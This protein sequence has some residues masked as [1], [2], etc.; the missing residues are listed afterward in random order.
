MRKLFVIALIL[1]TLGLWLATNQQ[2]DGPLELPH[3]KYEQGT[4]NQ[5]FDNMVWSHSS[6]PKLLV[7]YCLFQFRKTT[8]F[9]H[10]VLSSS[11]AAQAKLFGRALW[12]IW[13]GHTQLAK[14]TLDVLQQD[15]HWSLWGK[16]GLLELALHTGNQ[17]QLTSLLLQFNN[18]FLS[19]GNIALIQSYK[20]YEL[21]NT[22]NDLEWIRLEELLNKY[23]IKEIATDSKLLFLKSNVYFVRGQEEF[24]EELLKQ[25]HPQ[26]KNTAEYFYCLV[27]LA[28]LKSGPDN[29]KNII[30]KLAKD[31]PEDTE[32]VLEKVLSDLQ[33]SDPTVQKFALKEIYDIAKL[34]NK[35]SK[36]LLEIMESLLTYHKFEEAGQVFKYLDLNKVVLDDFVLFHTISAWNDI[37]KVEYDSALSKLEKALEMAPKDLAANWLKVLLIKKLERPD[38][39]LRPLKILFTANPYNQSYRNQI[40]YFR[41]NYDMPELESLYQRMIEHH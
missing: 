23:T 22:W 15:G 19:S 10:C 13:L 26:V 34:F 12:E 21:W 30:K 16:V 40:T 39:A 1:G 31:W 3:D 24:L 41:N 37:Y 14:E 2:D 29:S 9:T 11:S 7:K 6:D 20:H 32:I 17:I 18:D 36:L 27:Y 5:E 28:I 25:S 38:L 33:D 4:E 35:D 8:N